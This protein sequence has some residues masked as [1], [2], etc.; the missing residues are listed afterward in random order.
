MQS[1]NCF[2]QSHY[3]AIICFDLKTQLF[4]LK[5]VALSQLSMPEN[6]EMVENEPFNRVMT[7]WLK[8]YMLPFACT[9]KC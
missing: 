4:G 9:R 8:C 7:M 2:A 1:V 3:H 5:T 6:T